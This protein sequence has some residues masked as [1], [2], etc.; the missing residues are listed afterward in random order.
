[1][2][3][4]MLAEIRRRGYDFSGSVFDADRGYD[5]ERSCSG[6]AWCPTSSREKTPSAV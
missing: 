1:M 6:W 3:P 2:L 5:A 4:V